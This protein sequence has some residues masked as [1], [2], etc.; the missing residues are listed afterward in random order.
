MATSLCK[1]I[2]LCRFGPR[3][4]RLWMPLT[5]PRAIFMPKTE[6]KE[7]PFTMLDKRMQFSPAFND[8]NRSEVIVLLKFLSLCW[9][10]NETVGKE[11]VRVITNNG[12]LRLTFEEAEKMGLS[13]ASYSR[14]V[15]GLI[16]HGFLSITHQGSGLHRDANLYHFDT[17]WLKWGTVHFEAVTKQ[18]PRLQ[19][20]F[21]KGHAFHGPR[22]RNGKILRM[23]PEMIT[24][25]VEKLDL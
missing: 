19:V 16:G 4:R 11:R 2:W 8:L 21:Q 9:I 14:S 24:E 13:R 12:K 10:K 7:N 25:K 1:A 6:R 17:R 3:G 5:P 15:L 23:L 18:R 22:K 20:G